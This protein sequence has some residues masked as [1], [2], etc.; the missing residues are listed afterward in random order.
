MN[1]ISK[2]E[3]IE[4]YLNELSD[5][6]KELL[7][8]ALISQSESKENLNVSDLLR[9][10]AEIKKPLMED[11]QRLHKRRNN[12]RKI[13]ILYL[14]TGSLFYISFQ[15]VNSIRSSYFNI[16]KLFALF[17]LMIAF[18]GLFAFFISFMEPTKALSHQRT[19]IKTKE[20]PVLEY[21]IIHK[22]R[23]L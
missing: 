15:A 21:E 16:N 23:E 1:T 8:K 9:L 6:Y 10:D 20:K 13:G 2:D 4:K 19:N 14:F 18:F 22:W 11:Y 17:A 12:L 5:E 7:F 3:K